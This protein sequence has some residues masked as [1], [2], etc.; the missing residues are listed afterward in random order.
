M[1]RQVNPLRGNQYT[2]RGYCMWVVFTIAVVYFI[3]LLYKGALS[4][5]CDLEFI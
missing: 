5:T 2:A 1:L 3:Q 4:N